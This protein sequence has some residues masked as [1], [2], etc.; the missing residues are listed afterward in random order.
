VNGWSPLAASLRRSVRLLLCRGRPGILIIF[1]PS[2]R[3]KLPGQSSPLLPLALR[4][5][6]RPQGFLLLILLFLFML[7][8]LLALV[9]LAS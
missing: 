2:L 7:V 4:T 1:H 6:T 9:S 5:R 8:F 3:S